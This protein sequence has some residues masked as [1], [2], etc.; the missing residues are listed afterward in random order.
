MIPS[1]IDYAK[2]LLVVAIILQM[3]VFASSFYGYLDF[4]SMVNVRLYETTRTFLVLVALL[5]IA[6]KLADY[7]RSR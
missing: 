1:L 6:W 5:L 7:T 2:Y 3:L 4:F